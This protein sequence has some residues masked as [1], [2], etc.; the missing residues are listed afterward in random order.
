[1]ALELCFGVTSVLREQSMGLMLFLALG[2]WIVTL[3]MRGYT[4]NK[5]WPFKPRQRIKRPG[6]L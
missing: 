1:M 4:G 6:E 3:D 2:A 5:R